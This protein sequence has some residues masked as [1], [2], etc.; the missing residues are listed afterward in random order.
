LYIALDQEYITSKQFEE[1]KDAA[2][3]ISTQIENFVKY[4]RKR[5]ATQK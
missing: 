5:V 3:S 4:M 2:T 1:I